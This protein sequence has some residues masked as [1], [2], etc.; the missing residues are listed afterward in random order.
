VVTW[1]SVPS[2]SAS[3]SAA[4][5]ASCRTGGLIRAADAGA[6]HVVFGERQVMRAGLGAEVRRPL[7]AAQDVHRQRRGHMRDVQVCACHHVHGEKRRDRRRLGLGRPREAMSPRLALVERAGARGCGGH[8]LLVLGMDE[9]GEPCLRGKPQ[10]GHLRV[11]IGPGE[12]RELAVA[13]R[14]RGGREDLER[15][16]AC[17]PQSPE[18]RLRQ[19]HRRCEQ[20]EVGERAGREMVAAPRHP[21]G[22]I[23]AGVGDRHLEK[24]RDPALGRRAGLR[25]HAAPV[26]VGG[27]PDV[28]MDVDRAGQD[29]ESLRLHGGLRFW[30]RPRR[31]DRHDPSVRH[32]HRARAEAVGREHLP[33]PDGKIERHLSPSSVSASATPSRW[34]RCMEA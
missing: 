29:M 1:A 25:F 34:A 20:P 6:G 8:H 26:R 30:L 33:A 13:V 10:H 24:R 31:Q 18:G 11:G 5:S 2:A 22:R 23:A 14:G 3:H 28:A 32:R 15:D 12:A 17:I 7:E 19:F 16:H 4:R 27:A 9:D 21:I